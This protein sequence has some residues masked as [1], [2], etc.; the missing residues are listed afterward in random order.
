M[1]ARRLFRSL[2]LG[3][4][5]FFGCFDE[6]LKG[7]RFEP[8]DLS[9]P[10]PQQFH[11]LEREP[12]HRSWEPRQ[13]GL[14]KGSHRD[15]LMPR[16]L[17][18]GGEQDRVVGDGRGCVSHGDPGL[19][20]S[21]L[22]W[23]DDATNG[24]RGSHKV[25]Q[26][27]RWEVHHGRHRRKDVAGV[28]ETTSA[29]RKAAQRPRHPR[30]F[31]RMSP[32]HVGFLGQGSKECS[33]VAPAD[34]R[35]SVRDDDDHHERFGPTCVSDRCGVDGSWFD[36]FA[37]WKAYVCDRASSLCFV[38]KRCDLLGP[39]VERDRSVLEDED[40]CVHGAPSLPQR[41]VW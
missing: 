4:R 16:H 7:P 9:G 29:A 25:C 40:G 39:R 12:H 13:Q 37:K 38:H 36:R 14:S 3:F 8:N 17:E 32:Y 11:V 27:E 41:E 5:P 30:W 28:E 21:A 31:P 19:G 22:H 2:S 33:N 23:D 34:G 18:D 1:A 26:I 24:V 6:G 15:G 20:G 35:N 10:P